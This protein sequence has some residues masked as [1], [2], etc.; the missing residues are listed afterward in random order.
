M[1]VSKVSML[2]IPK[3]QPYEALLGFSRIE[4]CTYGSNV[5]CPLPIH[6]VTTVASE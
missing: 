4:L 1:V 2:G 3:F 5:S 6:W